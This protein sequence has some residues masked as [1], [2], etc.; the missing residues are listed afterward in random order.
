MSG[1]RGAA[2][3]APQRKRPCR[4]WA[5]PPI[6]P[7]FSCAG[8]ASLLRKQACSGS[9]RAYEAVA[10]RSVNCAAGEKARMRISSVTTSPAIPDAARIM[11]TMMN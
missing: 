4:S 10:G 11:A 6:D 3:K 5:L 1:E 2:T 7:T 9:K 8:G